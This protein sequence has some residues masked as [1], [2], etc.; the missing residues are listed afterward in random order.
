MASVYELPEIPALQAFVYVAVEHLLEA[1]GFER[2]NF[3]LS[4]WLGSP[5]PDDELQPIF[6]RFDPADEP[7][8]RR[9]IYRATVR[10]LSEDAPMLLAPDLSAPL[11][12]ISA[13]R[14]GM[15]Y[16]G[17]L[18]PEHQ[19]LSCTAPL[20]SRDGQRATVEI[21]RG[22]AGGAEDYRVTLRRVGEG[23]ERLP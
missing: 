11:P 12:I 17:A 16:E 21:Q 3:E 7:Y 13:Q 2:S 4:E 22:H 9:Q 15:L 10:C 5:N 19:V 14:L 18:P 20:L 23:W 8:L 6:D 1:E